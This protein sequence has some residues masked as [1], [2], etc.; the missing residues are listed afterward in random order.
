M[1]G[2]ISAILN[3]IGNFSIIVVALTLLIIFGWNFW[4]GLFFILAILSVIGF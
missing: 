4:T 3:F 2:I 1:G